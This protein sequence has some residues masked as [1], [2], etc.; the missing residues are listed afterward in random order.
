MS[1][2]GVNADAFKKENPELYK[3]LLEQ[4][5]RGKIT[6]TL[7]DEY[8]GFVL[9]IEG[10]DYAKDSNYYEIFSGPRSEL[11]NPT[12]SQS[13]AS[14]T[15]GITAQNQAIR[16]IGLSR[17]N[18]LSREEQNNLVELYANDQGTFNST[19]QQMFDNDPVWGDKYG[20]KNLN[21]SM[22]VGPYKTFYQNTFGEVADELDETFLEGVGLSQIEARKKYRTSAY[23]QRNEYFMS[24]MAEK[25]S[26][27]LGG[28]VLRDTRIG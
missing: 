21:Y 11:N 27:S 28:N 17:W 15:Q 12:W 23:A 13:N 20:G 7:L 6:S 22:V 26:S 2:I 10:F 9:G 4:T 5:I 25:I 19:M 8:L 24:E 18:G 3:N 1:D 14:Y 16:Y